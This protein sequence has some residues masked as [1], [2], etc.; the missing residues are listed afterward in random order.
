M[1]MQL[2]FS[3]IAALF[4]I[5]ESSPEGG[6]RTRICYSDGKAE[7]ISHRVKTV[8]RNTADYFSINIVRQRQRYGEYLQRR[9]GVPLPLSSGIVL[10]PL[11]ML[12]SS[13]YNDEV[14]GYVNACHVLKISEASPEEAALGIRCILHLKGGHRIPCHFSVKS[15]KRKVRTAQ[16]ALEHFRSLIGTPLQ[17]PDFSWQKD[18]PYFLRNIDRNL[19]FL[20]A[21]LYNSRDFFITVA[22]EE[23]PF[24]KKEDNSEN[25]SKEEDTS[26]FPPTAK[27]SS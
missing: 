22:E 14:T 11:K 19:S 23:D 8:L 13:L 21:L 9:Q 2:N 26:K 15:V 18:G 24:K 20:H 17:K 6:K 1:S 4:P 3:L 25:T 27:S 10:V 16:L 5:S 12:K 7:E